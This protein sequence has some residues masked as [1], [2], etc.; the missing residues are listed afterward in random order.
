MKLIVEEGVG[1]CGGGLGQLRGYPQVLQGEAV[2]EA[3]QVHHAV[4]V[5]GSVLFRR[6]GRSFS[7][8]CLREEAGE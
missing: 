4:T 5:G 8:S 6:W 7:S 2:G 3:V 1:G